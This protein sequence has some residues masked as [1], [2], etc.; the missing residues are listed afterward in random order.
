VPYILS[1]VI[2]TLGIEV[3]N[4][5]ASPL[6]SLCFVTKHETLLDTCDICNSEQCHYLVVIPPGAC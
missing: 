3:V 5:R 1:T 2:E 4:W 6:Y